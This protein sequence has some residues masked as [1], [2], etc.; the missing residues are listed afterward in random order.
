MLLWVL[1]NTKIKI[2]KCAKTHIQMRLILKLKLNSNFNLT[3]AHFQLQFT[4]KKL[5]NERIS[6][7]LLGKEDYLVPF[8]T[9]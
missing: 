9:T 6:L 1:N 5:R 4:T 8:N 7:S 3:Y 2:Y